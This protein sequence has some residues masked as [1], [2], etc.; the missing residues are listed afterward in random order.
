MGERPQVK[1]APRR[2]KA[3]WKR[4]S[5]V[6]ALVPLVLLNVARGDTLRTARIFADHMVVQ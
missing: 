6:A 5:W 4:L 3:I 1:T 2:H